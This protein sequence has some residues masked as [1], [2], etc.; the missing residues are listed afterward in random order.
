VQG[1]ESSPEDGDSIFLRN[2]DINQRFYTAPKRRRKTSSSAPW[3]PQI[4]QLCCYCRD[5]IRLCP[6]GTG[7]LTGPLSIPQLIHQWIW[8]SGG[9]I[10][11]G[12]NRRT[13][14]KGCRGST[15]CTTKPT[16]TDLG[17][18]P[19]LSGKKP[20]KSR[21]S[22]GTTAMSYKGSGSVVHQGTTT[23]F[24]LERLMLLL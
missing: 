1:S 11:T 16:L 8:S 18:N 13:R 19:G 6:Y 22:Y 4:S 15:L 23:G 14:K 5:G 7:P 2:A 24:F 9:M 3:E 10:L 20:T 12:E 17:A 21:P